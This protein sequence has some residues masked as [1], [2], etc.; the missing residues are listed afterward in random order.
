MTKKI[1]SIKGRIDDVVVINTGE[2]PEGRRWT[3]Y[4]VTINN[5]TFR[6]FDTGYEKLIGKEG[7]WFYESEVRKSSGGK[8]YESKTLISLSKVKKLKHQTESQIQQDNILRGLGVIRGDIKKLKEEIET[9][10]KSIEDALKNINIPQ[11]NKKEVKD[12]T[13]NEETKSEN[14]PVYEEEE[15]P[16]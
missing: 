10:L 5:Q 9:R 7:E 3:L 15:I 8:T 12:D 14:I 6:T 11:E 2:T 1:K 4:E 16:F 13:E